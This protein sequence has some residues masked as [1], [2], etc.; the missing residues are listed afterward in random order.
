MN[1]NDN[2][3]G[4]WNAEETVTGRIPRLAGPT[5]IGHYTTVWAFE[6][7]LKYNEQENEQCHTCIHIS[8]NLHVLVASLYIHIQYP[9]TLN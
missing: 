7:S 3:P 4:S 2:S 1:F 9:L 6:I 5:T 8:L